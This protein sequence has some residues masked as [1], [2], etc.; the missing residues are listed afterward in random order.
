GWLAESLGAAR[1][2]EV[3]RERLRR[4]AGADPTSPLDPAAV[5]RLDAALAAR[6]DEAMVGVDAA[7]RSP[8][9]LALVD[10]LVLAA[11]TPRLTPPAQAAAGRVLPAL[12][13]KPWR[14]LAGAGGREGGAGALDPLGPDE[15][16][17]DVRK[18]GKRARSAVTAVAPVLGGEAVR[19][20]RALARV[21]DLLGEHQDAVVAAQTWLAVAD[22]QPQN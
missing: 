4:T 5:D 16:W 6:Q 19:L 12:V 9:Y 18:D 7:L 3:L 11:R 13:A 10:A 1:D 21:Q 8:R 2:A 14:K 20:G 22:D 17:H 15:R